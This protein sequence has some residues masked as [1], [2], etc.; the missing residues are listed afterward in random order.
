MANRNLKDASSPIVPDDIQEDLNM[1]FEGIP[2]ESFMESK[3]RIS[4]AMN[5]PSEIQGNIKNEQVI[6]GYPNSITQRSLADSDHG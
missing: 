4:I 1:N 5:I 6:N 3:R 2:A